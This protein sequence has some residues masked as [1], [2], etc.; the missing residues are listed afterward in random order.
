VICGFSGVSETEILEMQNSSLKQV[1]FT[2]GCSDLWFFWSLRERD[3]G[4][5]E[6]QSQAG[7]LHSRVQC[8]VV[9]S[10]VSESEILEMQN[11]SLK[12]VSFTEGVQ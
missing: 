12:Q 10:G 8:F 1:S 3:T 6:L 11:S 2:V 5:A 9:F 4:D 7:K